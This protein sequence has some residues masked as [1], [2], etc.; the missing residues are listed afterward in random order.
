MLSALEV[1]SKVALVGGGEARGAPAAHKT[2]SW[3]RDQVSS[4]SIESQGVTK[5]K[6]F[7]SLTLESQLLGKA[8]GSVVLRICKEV[9]FRMK[10][11][12]KIPSFGERKTRRKLLTLGVGNSRR[13]I[14]A[15]GMSSSWWICPLPHRWG[16]RSNLWPKC[17]GL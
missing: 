14:R 3:S 13:S 11:L 8:G 9:K 12:L 2:G 15:P 17:F 7:L 4:K 6:V 5:S 16:R 10:E 1:P